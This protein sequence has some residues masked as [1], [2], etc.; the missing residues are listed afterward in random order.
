MVI[1]L[2]KIE[3]IKNCYLSSM[4]TNDFVQKNHAQ[5]ANIK[6]NRCFLIMVLSPEE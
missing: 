5:V 6:R 3:F 1:N 4:K 2:I